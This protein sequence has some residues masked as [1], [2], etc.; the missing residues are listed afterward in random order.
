MVQ[1]AF[2]FT[3]GGGVIT[4]IDLSGEPTAMAELQVETRRSGS[5]RSG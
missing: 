2:G 4:A 5:W 1:V 3:I